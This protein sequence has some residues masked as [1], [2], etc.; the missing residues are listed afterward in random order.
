MSDLSDEKLQ[1]YRVL[2]PYRYEQFLINKRA[3]FEF[4][5]TIGKWIVSSLLLLNGAAIAAMPTLLNH[6]SISIFIAGASFILSLTAALK[7]GYFT[8]AHS[9]AMVDRYSYYANPSML[10]SPEYDRSNDDIPEF[11]SANTER[12][13]IEDTYANKYKRYGIASASL[14]I[15]GIIAVFVSFFQQTKEP[16]TI[17]SLINQENCFLFCPWF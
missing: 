17:M 13:R 5:L 3:A 4:Q 15:V 10:H 1:I 8:W 11:R 2:A 14:F 16:R 9:Q 7:T 6:S 12:K